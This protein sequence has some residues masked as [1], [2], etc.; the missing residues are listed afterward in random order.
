MIKR[1]EQHRH[2]IAWLERFAG[3]GGVAHGVGY[4]FGGD[5]LIGCTCCRSE[6]DNIAPKTEFDSI[7]AVVIDDYAVGTKTAVCPLPGRRA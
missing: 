7:T 1:V 4:R 2:Y 6:F 5:Y 3:A